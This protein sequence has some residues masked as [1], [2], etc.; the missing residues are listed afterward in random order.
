MGGSALGGFDSQMGECDRGQ[1]W[2]GQG[3]GLW[4]QKDGMAISKWVGA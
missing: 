1:P 4:V 2:Q 3:S